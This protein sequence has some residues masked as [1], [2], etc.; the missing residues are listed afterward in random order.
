VC[1]LGADY[2]GFILYLK[3]SRALSIERAIELSLRVPEGKRVAVDV[4]PDLEKLAQMQAGGFDYFQLHYKLDTPVETL[5][6]WSELVGKDRLWLAPSVGPDDAFPLLALTLADTILLDTYAKQQI[7][8]TGRVG[9]WARFAYL[10]QSH[11]HLHWILAGG[12]GPEN[13]L[14]ALNATHAAH[15][16]FNSGVEHSPGIKD[17]EKLRT[18]FSKLRPK[19]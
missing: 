15:L 17:P 4:A 5:T 2:C 16:D 8:G 11:P 18:V 9:D 3:S 12:L 19:A 1:S 7:G 10:K 13:A 6:A 14:D